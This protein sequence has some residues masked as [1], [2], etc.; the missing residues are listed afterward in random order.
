MQIAVFDCQFPT[1]PAFDA[2]QTGHKRGLNW[3]LRGL[4]IG[5]L[6]ARYLNWRT[7]LDGRLMTLSEHVIKRNGL[8]SYLDQQLPS[9]R[10]LRRPRAEGQSVKNDIECIANLNG[11]VV[12]GD[13]VIPGIVR[14]SH[15]R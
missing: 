15:D 10:V 1:A 11:N 9:C 13:R 4:W 8:L 6:T 3:R 14:T 5:G 7:A 12:P 2:M